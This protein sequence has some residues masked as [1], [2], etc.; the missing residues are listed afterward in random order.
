[1]AIAIAIT[2]A[3]GAA[4]TALAVSADT[5]SSGP[6]KD[7]LPPKPS[8]SSDQIQLPEP[9]RKVVSDVDAPAGAGGET[10]D[11]SATDGATSPSSSNDAFRTDGGAGASALNWSWSVPYSGW[12]RFLQP[13]ESP[14]ADSVTFV[15]S[16]PPQGVRSTATASLARVLTSV[17]RTPVYLW[18]L[19]PLGLVMLW[20]AGLAVFEPRA[21]GSRMLVLAGSVRRTAR[22][23]PA[24]M[25]RTVARAT[26]RAVRGFGRWGRR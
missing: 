17:P 12:R 9:L 24:G 15:T 16:G 11:P 2:V 13:G 14:Y 6:I 5:Y 1:M 7:R 4:G 23:L 18:V 8:P 22:K 26:I 3:L 21:E 19:L 25:I 20:A 10:D